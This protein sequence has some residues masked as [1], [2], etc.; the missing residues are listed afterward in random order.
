MNFNQNIG[1]LTIIIN[2][3][4]PQSENVEMKANRNFESKEEE[5][6]LRGK[7][8]NFWDA[9]FSIGHEDLIDGKDNGNGDDVI[10]DQIG[11]VDD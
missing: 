10:I 2:V 5:G 8:I 1:T 4:F 11:Q 7:K 9:V 6:T 3:H